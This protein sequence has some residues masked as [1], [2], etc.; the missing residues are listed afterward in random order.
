MSITGNYS[1]PTSYLPTSYGSYGL[2][3]L[4]SSSLLG[5]SASPLDSFGDTSG[6]MGSTDPTTMDPGTMLQQIVSLLGM[7]INVIS[8]LFQS[9]SGLSGSGQYTDPSGLMSGYTDP[10]QLSGTNSLY[11]G[12]DSSLY[13]GTNN[14]YSG[15]TD[16]SSLDLTSPTGT[17]SLYSDPN[18]PLNPNASSSIYNYYGQGDPTST[19][20]TGSY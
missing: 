3:T 4:G 11:S 2:N 1:I 13:G 5:N 19:S 18:N 7:M 14:L 12:L 9:N 16:P 17:N 8:S 10:S 20:S 6:L 15:Y